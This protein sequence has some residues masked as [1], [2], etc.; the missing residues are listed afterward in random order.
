M[1]SGP[2]ISL[3]TAAV[4]AEAADLEAAGLAAEV[5]EAEAEEAEEAE[6]GEG[7]NK[8]SWVIP[9]GGG[10]ARGQGASK[11]KRRKDRKGR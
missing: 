11:R 1:V 7:F 2:A 10:L 3:R 6:P 9:L 8:G 4:V 5:L